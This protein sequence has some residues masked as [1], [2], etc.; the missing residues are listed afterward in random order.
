MNVTEQELK[1]YNHYF[2]IDYFFDDVRDFYFKQMCMGEIS[3]IEYCKKLNEIDA[4]VRRSVL[5][6][7]STSNV[8][9]LFYRKED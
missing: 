1:D 4:K 3:E 6:I 2:F 7:D 5:K 9:D 8:V